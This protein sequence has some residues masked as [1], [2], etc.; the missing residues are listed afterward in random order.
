[1]RKSGKRLLRDAERR[2][3][4]DAG[5]RVFVSHRAEVKRKAADLKDRL[6]VFGVSA[7]VAH[8]D[9]KPTRKWQDEIEKALGSM[10]AF[11]ALLTAKFHESNWTDQEIGYA[12]CRKVPLIAVKFGTTPYGFVGRFQALQC[13]WGE[14]P[15]EIAK[16]LITK[17]SM[18]D[19][20]VEAV[21][22]CGSFDDGNTLSQ[23]LPCIEALTEEQ[24]E[25]LVL[26]FNKNSQLQGSYGFNGTKSWKFG[27]GLTAHLTSLTGNKYVMTESKKP[28]LNSFLIK[29]KKR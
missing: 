18:L 15:L 17:P 12:L 24:A 2:I 1:M 4:G 5:Y 25:K 13:T 8:A 3:W 6:A 11:V 14:A 28:W 10:D 26:A 29:R 20:Y 19:A 23:V 9:V 27:P 22:N 16:L 7:F 21:R